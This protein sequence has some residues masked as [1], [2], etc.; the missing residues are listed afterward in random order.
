MDSKQ[1][2]FK[3]GPNEAGSD[4]N[5][6]A[7]FNV[8]PRRSLGQGDEILRGRMKG[9]GDWGCIQNS[10]NPSRTPEERPEDPRDPLARV[11][12]SRGSKNSGFCSFFLFP[13]RRKRK[14]LCRSRASPDVPLLVLFGVLNSFTVPTMVQP[15]TTV[16]T[17]SFSAACGL[18]L[19]LI[20]DR[21]GQGSQKLSQLLFRQVGLRFCR[22]RHCALSRISSSVLLWQ[23]LPKGTLAVPPATRHPGYSWRVPNFP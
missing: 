3:R 10:R 2:H 18:G 20:L 9:G 22:W 4:Q 14:L 23:P 7:H 13:S 16:S 15:M 17:I 8:A 11:D 5:R 6:R 19:L 21:F 1:T 12:Y